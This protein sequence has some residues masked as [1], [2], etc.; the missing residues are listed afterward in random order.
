M[1]IFLRR[2]TDTIL[3]PQNYETKRE[4]VTAWGITISLGIISFGLVQA[5]CAI[6]RS[7]L[8][9]QRSP[10]SLSADRVSV[11]LQNETIE[12][13]NDCSSRLRDLN[14]DFTSSSWLDTT[15]IRYGLLELAAQ[16]G[17]IVSTSA[18]R[19]I[20]ELLERDYQQLTATF[21]IHLHALNIGGH[22]VAIVIDCD[23]KQVEYY[24]STSVGMR[25]DLKK[26]LN[27]LV[28]RVS[29]N[30]KETFALVAPLK[31][32]LQ[33]DSFQCGVW[34]LYFLKQRIENPEIDFNSL[35]NP[36]KEIAKYRD[37]LRGTI[38]QVAK[39]QEEANKLIRQAYPEPMAL[40]QDY[41]DLCDGLPPVI[42]GEFYQGFLLRHYQSIKNYVQQMNSQTMDQRLIPHLVSLDSASG[43]GS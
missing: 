38:D 20:N 26:L 9:N 5:I 32:K 15:H 21:P 29:E 18:H 28:E 16:K 41:R 31:K 33:N 19:D 11:V 30:K 6:A 27:T 42:A 7:C 34:T 4:R 2:F 12:K 3:S 10:K 36:K 39:I 1:N 23:K 43:T 22:W 24:D 40:R 37:S 13:T 35:A 17:V 8:S 14:L 25:N